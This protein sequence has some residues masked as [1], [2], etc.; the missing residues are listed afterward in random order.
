MK[1][2][3][4]QLFHIY[5][6]GN[7]RQTIFFTDE[8]YRYFLWKMRAYLLPFGDLVAYSL[9][10]THYHWQFFV[11]KVEIERRALHK[12]VDEVEFLR[13]LKMFGS[14]AERVIRVPSR[15]AKEGD[16]ASLNESIGILQRAYTRAIN[17]EKDWTGSLF[18]K[19]CKAKDGWEE[20]FI[21]LRKATGKLDHR[22]M[23]G[24]DYA[25]TC[26]CYLHDNARKAGLVRNNEDW[27][28]SSARDYANLRKGTLCNLEIGRRIID[29]L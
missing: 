26:F 11:R 19:K 17:K 1:F 22:F 7:N 13:R 5:N 29:F 21:T 18:R 2:Y 25:Y 27:I 15:Q 12:H 16:L 4:N 20:G 10:P 23:P 8:N 3:A 24:T 9:M 6:Q 28:Y 14:K